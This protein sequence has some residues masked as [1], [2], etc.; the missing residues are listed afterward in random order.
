M[1]NKRQKNFDDNCY[2]QKLLERIL[3]SFFKKYTL[4][5]LGRFTG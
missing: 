5:Q 4:C 2:W 3:D 1:Y